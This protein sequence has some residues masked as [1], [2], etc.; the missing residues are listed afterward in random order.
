MTRRVVL[1]PIALISAALAVAVSAAQGPPLGILRAGGVTV[2]P[3]ADTTD[4][5]CAITSPADD[6]HDNGSDGTADFSGTSSDASGVAS[7]T[8]SINT[9]AS[10]TA[11]GTTSWSVTGATLVNGSNTVTVTCSDTVG[12]TATDTVVFSYSAAAGPC[13]ALAGACIDSVSDNTPAVDQSI[14]LAGQDFYQYVT[15]GLSPYLAANANR[16][17]FEGTDGASVTTLGY[18]ATGS[19]GT[20]VSAQKIIGSKSGR[21]RSSGPSGSACPPAGSTSGQVSFLYYNG[22]GAAVADVYFG[23]YVRW[24]PYVGWPDY[25]QKMWGFNNTGFYLMPT[26]FNLVTNTT[27]MPTTFDIISN[28]DGSRTAFNINPDGGQLEKQKWYWIDGHSKTSSTTDFTLRVNGI[29]VYSGS[30]TANYTNNQNDYFPIGFINGCGSTSY[31]LDVWLDGMSYASQRV[32][33]PSEVWL[34]DGSGDNPRTGP[35]AAGCVWQFTTTI[36]DTSDVFTFRKTGNGV[37]VPSG[38]GYLFVVNQEREL[39][40]GIAVTVP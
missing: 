7:V 20:I 37:T 31:G 12:H 27:W 13:V 11:T 4:P 32:Y 21:F 39:S 30:P 35:A 18:G 14:T 23:K 16:G 1:I 24:D 29:Q 22:P 17:S 36:S 2:A 8:Y 9:G 6:P 25:Y 34:C 5:T 19:D 38:T 15:T 26:S 33:P 3:A 28:A 40:A 10:G